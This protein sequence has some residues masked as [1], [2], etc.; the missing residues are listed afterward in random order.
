MSFQKT[1]TLYRN[2][3]RT[4]T[5]P[6]R[7][8]EILEKKQCMS[9]KFRQTVDCVSTYWLFHI[10]LNNKILFFLFNPMQWPRPMRWNVIQTNDWTAT[11]I[12]SFVVCSYTYL[13]HIH[14]PL[15]ISSFKTY[16]FIMVRRRTTAP[17]KHKSQT[18]KMIK[19]NL[20]K[21]FSS[22]NKH[23]LHSMY[24]YFAMHDR[25]MNDLESAFLYLP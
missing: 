2:T 24:S 1:W 17:R 21:K 6:L 3:R 9:S 5:Q 25:N 8:S 22:G 23:L 4:H 15:V 7:E 14:W 13:I 20:K 12:H 19:K 18:K 16:I 11:I 10:R